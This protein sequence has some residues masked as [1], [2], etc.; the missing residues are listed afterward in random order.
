M[1]GNNQS[2]QYR[3][4]ESWEAHFY[5][6]VT[7]PIRNTN[8]IYTNTQSK[9]IGQTAGKT[10]R[11]KTARLG[12]QSKCVPVRTDAYILHIHGHTQPA[13]V[14]HQDNLLLF[15]KESFLLFSGTLL[16]HLL[17]L[18]RLPGLFQSFLFY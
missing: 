15:F 14:Q 13:T 1:L 10:I 9:V 2:L 5:D 7:K 16:L 12:A 4:T 3:K 11:K 6:I 17:F 18:L 8:G